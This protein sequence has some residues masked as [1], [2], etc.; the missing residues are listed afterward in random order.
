M[1][2]AIKPY[3]KL[4]AMKTLLT[5][6]ILAWA[7][8]A[9]ILLVRNQ[10]QTLLIGMDENGVRVIRDERDRLVAG[11]KLNFIK[12]YL[13]Y[14]YNFDSKD[15]DDRMTSAGN[16]MSTKLWEE[17]ASEFK[18][19]REEAKNTPEITQESTIEEIRFIDDYTFE[20]DLGLKISKRLKTIS[21]PLRVTIKIA[22]H[23]RTIDNP[24]SWE[25]TSY[26]ENKR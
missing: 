13:S 8:T 18:K 6:V 25:V 4:Q 23:L 26:V 19:I 3:F 12:R 2:D 15:Y 24:Y 10:P 1:I 17:K 20:A 5:A 9:S 7:A 14:S 22:P 21:V 16:L 11:E